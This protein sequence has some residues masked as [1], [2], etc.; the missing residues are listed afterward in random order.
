VRVREPLAAAAHAAG[1]VGRAD[2]VCRPPLGRANV[3]SKSPKANREVD[4]VL[5]S[6]RGNDDERASTRQP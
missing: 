2:S 6:S 4:A 5:A 1:R 3:R